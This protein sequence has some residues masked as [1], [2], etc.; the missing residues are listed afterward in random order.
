V[1]TFS[2]AGSFFGPC[3]DLT[4]V[5]FATGF[6][7]FTSTD[8]AG[9]L[10][11]ADTAGAAEVAFALAFALSFASSAFTSAAIKSEDLKKCLVDP[12]AEKEVTL[13]NREVK[14]NVMK[15]VS[16][17]LLTPTKRVLVV[18]FLLSLGDMTSDPSISCIEEYP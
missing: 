1:P 18:C 2:A 3:V 13:P 14:P 6:V 17:I 5:Y 16:F 4:E 7:A 11:G 9:A 15:R 12:T 10:A 8:F